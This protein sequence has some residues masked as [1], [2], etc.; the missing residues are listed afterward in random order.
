MNLRNCLSQLDAKPRRMAPGERPTEKAI[1][2][3]GE[4]LRTRRELGAWAQAGE[5][6][7]ALADVHATRGEWQQ[8][9]EA[10]GQAAEAWEKI[11]G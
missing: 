2:R 11:S 7:H 6:L 5:T 8:A 9:A 1:A 4:A 3:Y 10:A